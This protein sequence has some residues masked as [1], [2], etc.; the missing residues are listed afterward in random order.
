[1]VRAGW[2][3]LKATHLQLDEDPESFLE[4][5]KSL[6]EAAKKAPFGESASRKRQL[7]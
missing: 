3:L 1:L 2:K 6:L 7:R 4:A 5:L